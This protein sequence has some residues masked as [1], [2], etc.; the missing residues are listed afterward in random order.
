MQFLS[1]VATN[2]LPD[3][4]EIAWGGGGG[5][6]GQT[7]RANAPTTYIQVQNYKN[8]VTFTSNTYKSQKHNGFDFFNVC[9]NHASLNY[10]GQESKNNLELMVLS[11]L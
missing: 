11:N 6:E 8:R 4:D 7:R 9:S 3:F 2:H 5:E 10:R 1:K